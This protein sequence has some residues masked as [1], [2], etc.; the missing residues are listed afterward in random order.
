MKFLG[1][2]LFSLASAFTHGQRE[3]TSPTD[4]LGPEAAARSLNPA[5]F[6]TDV[7]AKILWF[8]LVAA[9]DLPRMDGKW[10][11]ADA[12]ARM[13][14][15]NKIICETDMIKNRSDPVWNKKCPAIL[16]PSDVSEITVEFEW[17]DMDSKTMFQ[18]IDG[19]FDVTISMD[20]L[21]SGEV[22]EENKMYNMIGFEWNIETEGFQELMSRWTK[23]GFLWRDL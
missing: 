14:Y 15:K 13:Y 7:Q 22:F 20:T 23:N 9:T 3:D 2:N 10:G 21:K 16:V 18:I 8:T 5:E 11:K 12:K 4:A 17:I 1:V 6:V 19:P